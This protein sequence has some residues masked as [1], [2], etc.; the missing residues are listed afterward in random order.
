MRLIRDLRTRLLLPLFPAC[1]LHT[2]SP[3]DHA[4]SPLHHHANHPSMGKKDAVR[5]RV[6][7]CAIPVARATGK[8]LLITSRKRPDS[9]VCESHF[10]HRR[11]RLHLSPR[12]APYGRVH[13]T[14][15]TLASTV[16]KG[17]WE[18][19]D[20]TLEAAAQRE[21]VEEGPALSVS[22]CRAAAS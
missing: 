1:A 18:P 4:P 22:L 11:R 17:G 13:N 8:I 16:P 12:R 14:P 9:W 20:R 10:L 15:L 6:V 21:A 19:T 2:G 7:C 5:P 3:V